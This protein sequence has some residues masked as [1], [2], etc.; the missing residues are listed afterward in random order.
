MYHSDTDQE[1]PVIH[2]Q[3]EHRYGPSHHALYSAETM[4][5]MFAGKNS[6]GSSDTMQMND[7]L[8]ALEDIHLSDDQQKYLNNLDRTEHSNVQ[9]KKESPKKGAEPDDIMPNMDVE[10]EAG[11]FRDNQQNP[12]HNI[13][14]S[15]EN[16][17]AF[18][19]QLLN[20]RDVSYLGP[21]FIGT[22][23]SQGAMVVYDTGSDWLTVKA[24]LTDQHCNKKIDKKATIAK[25]GPEKAGEV[26]DEDD[27]QLH[28]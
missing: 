26:G 12:T 11:G 21:V 9:L 22:P 15:E 2:V 10:D 5:N 23:Y 25:Y 14:D 19:T 20:S 8:Q 27:L 7:Y 3:L 24:C 1:H 28:Q 16:L 18:R 17:K 4:R 13:Y 6:G